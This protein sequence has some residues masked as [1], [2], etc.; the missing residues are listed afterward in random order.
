MQC[1][2]KAQS[3]MLVKKLKEEKREKIFSYLKE[4][5]NYKSVDKII[6]AIQLNI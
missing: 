1:L 6:N 5:S 2:Y 4:N 3:D